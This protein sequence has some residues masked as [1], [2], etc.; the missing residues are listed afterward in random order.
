M[1]KLLLAIVATLVLASPAS[2]ARG[3]TP[4]QAA[5]KL[6]TWTTVDQKA[7][8]YTQAKLDKL[9]AAGTPETDP[10][11]VALRSA[12]KSIDHQA[13]VTSA[14]CK[15]AGRATSGRYSRFRCSVKVLGSAR[16]PPDYVLY[17]ATVKVTVRLGP[18]RVSEGWR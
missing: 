3:W 13:K 5:A 8:D 16:I 7:H 12:L 9:L 15:G 17:T 11:V 10:Q 14:S 4:T 18:Y 2:A 6:K 1:P